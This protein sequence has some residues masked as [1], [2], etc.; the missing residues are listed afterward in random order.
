[1][2]DSSGAGEARQGL[3]RKRGTAVARLAMAART[4]VL[5]T[6]DADSRSRFDRL[7]NLDR[8]NGRSLPCASWADQR[9]PT[10]SLRCLACSAPPN[11]DTTRGP[12]HRKALPCVGQRSLVCHPLVVRPPW[13]PCCVCISP[14]C[15]S[16]D[17]LTPSGQAQ[18]IQKSTTFSPR[19]CRCHVRPRG[20]NFTAFERPGYKSLRK[21]GIDIH[22]RVSKLRD[23]PLR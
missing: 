7:S 20:I 3:E 19:I 21:L 23:L 4:R 9:R 1:M 8:P 6:P 22:S 5:A 10:P 17:V 12:R 11:H 15:L 2:K 14:Y 16:P 18:A 13:L